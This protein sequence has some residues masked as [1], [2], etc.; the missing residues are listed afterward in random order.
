[1]EDRRAGTTNAELHTML[2]RLEGTLDL[3]KY[4]VL[5]VKEMTQKNNV[6]LFGNG[7]AGILEEHKDLKRCFENHENEFVEIKK[8]AKEKAERYSVRT[9]AV[10]MVFITQAAGLLFLFLRPV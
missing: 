2:T 3:I 5:A 8:A 1:M 6:A 4:D 7:K 9:W 10:V